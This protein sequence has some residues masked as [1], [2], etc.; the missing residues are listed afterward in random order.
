MSANVSP[1]ISTMFIKWCKYLGVW[2][3]TVRANPILK[4]ESWASGE[5]ATGIQHMKVIIGI[6]PTT[7]ARRFVLVYPQIKNNIK[8]CKYHMCALS[9]LGEPSIS[10]SRAIARSSVWAFRILILSWGGVCWVQKIHGKV[11]GQTDG[12][13]GGRTDGQ[14]QA[15]TVRLRPEMPRDNKCIVHL[16]YNDI[17]HRKLA[18]LVSVSICSAYLRKTIAYWSEDTVWHM[19]NLLGMLR[20]FCCHRELVTEHE[21]R[22][23]IEQFFDK[24]SSYK[25]F[26]TSGVTLSVAIDHSAAIEGWNFY[27]H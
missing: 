1:K 27:N 5:D 8:W 25:F 7:S 26:A 6:C 9:I 19:T 12:H 2:Y 10:D 22:V 16:V 21:L 24:H 18:L 11:Y 14:T 20:G 17:Q 15:T 4:A 13:T 3:H 23:Q